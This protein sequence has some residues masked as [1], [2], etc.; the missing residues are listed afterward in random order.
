MA[1]ANPRDVS[2]IAAAPE[3]LEALEEMCSGWPA[4]KSESKYFNTYNKA[5]AVIAKAKGNQ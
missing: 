5:M 4:Q 3:L 2:L 1:Y